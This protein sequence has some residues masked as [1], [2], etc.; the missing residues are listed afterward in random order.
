[1]VLM[2]V[3]SVGGGGVAR[4]SRDRASSTLTGLAIATKDH[5]VIKSKV[6]EDESGRCIVVA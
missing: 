1:M 6:E 2:K 3:A 5:R 4:F